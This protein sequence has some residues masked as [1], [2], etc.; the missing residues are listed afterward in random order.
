MPIDPRLKRAPQASANG[1]LWVHQTHEYVG[2]TDGT[3]W[4]F[5]NVPTFRA[6]NLTV[7]QLWPLGLTAVQ[8]EAINNRTEQIL[9]RDGRGTE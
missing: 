3:E 4:R 8:M 6:L 7:E 5:F 1:H 2:I 9:E